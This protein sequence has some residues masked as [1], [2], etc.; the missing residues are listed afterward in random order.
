MASD[1]GLHCL[2]MFQEKDARLKWVKS[3][4]NVFLNAVSLIGRPTVYIIGF[5]NKISFLSIKIVLS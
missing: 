5:E 2:L 4:A 3:S 1:L